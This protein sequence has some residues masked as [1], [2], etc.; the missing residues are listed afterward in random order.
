MYFH[1]NKLSFTNLQKINPQVLINLLNNVR[2]T[3][4]ALTRKTAIVIKKNQNLKIILQNIKIEFFIFCKNLLK[5]KTFK[6]VYINYEKY[7]YNLVE[8]MCLYTKGEK[9][10]VLDFCAAIGIFI[11]HYC[12]HP[13]LS[14]AGN[15]RMCLIQLD[16]SIKPIA[17]C[18]ITM[19]PKMIINTQSIF[20][21]KLQEVS[22]NFFY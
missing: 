5:T 15:C 11:P 6:Y 2:F 14:I 19:S 13:D 8:Y 12:Y 9:F 18:A 3:Y 4:P 16:G 20:V 21:K 17:S 1:I 22:W 10:S 7:N